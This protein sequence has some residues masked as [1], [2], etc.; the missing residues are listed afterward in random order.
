M[1]EEKQDRWVPKENERYWTLNCAR[2]GVWTTCWSGEGDLEDD[3][4]YDRE[5]LDAGLVFRTKEEAEAV[6]A[7]MSGQKEQ[8]SQL[9]RGLTPREIA[10]GWR[11]W[12]GGA[13]CPVDNGTMV[14]IKRDNRPQG[15]ESIGMAGSFFFW[16]NTSGPDKITAYRVVKYDAADRSVCEQPPV[17]AASVLTAAPQHM[18]DRAATYDRPEGERSMAAT[19]A[20][21]NAITGA[22]MTEAQGWLFMAVLKQVRLFQRP[23]YHADSAEDAAAYVALMAEAKA[24]EVWE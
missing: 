20:A 18:Q 8:A 9:T 4:E 23:G 24:K 13:A 16:W 12:E 6:L 17:T 5:Q 21:F 2:S 10:D 14:E 1:S 22:E 3:Q 19:V 7:K 11:Y 15:G